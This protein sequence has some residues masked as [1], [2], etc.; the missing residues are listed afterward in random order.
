[1]EVPEVL[2]FALRVS[3][4]AEA[5]ENLRRMKSIDESFSIRSTSIFALGRALLAEGM[6]WKMC[7]KRFKERKFWLFNDILVYAKVIRKEKCFHSQ[8]VIRLETAEVEDL[9]NSMFTENSTYPWIFKSPKKSFVICANRAE[10]KFKRG[11]NRKEEYAPI[12]IPDDATNEC[13]RCYQSQFGLIKRKHHCRKCGAIVCGECSSNQMVIKGQSDIPQ[14]VCIIC[15]ERIKIRTIIRY[16]KFD[17]MP[18]RFL[19]F[20]GGLAVVAGMVIEVERKGFSSQL[21]HK[22]VNPLKCDEGWAQF[23]AYCYKN[24]PAKVSYDEA[25]K[26]C[27]K[28][29]SRLVTIHGYLENRFVEEMQTAAG[30]ACWLGLRRKCSK[31]G[32]EN[33]AWTDGSANEFSNWGIGNP[34]PIEGK[35]RNWVVVSFDLQQLIDIKFQRVIQRC[36]RLQMFNNS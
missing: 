35:I 2:K 13:M 11:E 8:R 20:T 3:D 22:E 26:I 10:E 21:S 1:M 29:G 24:H 12:M 34:D 30:V 15:F 19:L 36:C 33:F 28:A 18:F 16:Q 27:R 6:L 31:F 9:R 5:P 7:R 25:K 32:F 4:I 17:Q 14:R 23:N